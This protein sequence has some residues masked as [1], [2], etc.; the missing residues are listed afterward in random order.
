MLSLGSIHIHWTWSERHI[1]RTILVSP[2]IAPRQ[3]TAIA[4]DVRALVK[5]SETISEATHTLSSG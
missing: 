2:G 4:L 3:L 1:V 5:I